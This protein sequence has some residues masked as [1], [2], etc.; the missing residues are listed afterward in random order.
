MAFG[1]AST[2]ARRGGQSDEHVRLMA[3]VA[4]MYHEKGLRQADIAAELHI[5]QP[6]VSR[7]LKQAVESG[8]VRTTVS[9]PA[10]VHTDLED[11]LEAAYG[12][13]EAVVVEAGGSESDVLRAL[14][15]AAAVYLETTFIGGDEVGISSWSAS[16]L[17][18]V[19]AMRP[20]STP[21]VS[22]VVQLVGGVG[23]PR[24]Q[25]DATR[26][27]TRL[28]SV[29]GAAPIFLPSP[30]LLGS[31]EARRSLMADPAVEQVTSLWPA[32]TTALVGIGALEPSPLLQQSGNSISAVD[33]A[34]LRAAGA[35]G[36][37]CLRYFDAAGEPVTTEFDERVIGITPEALRLIPR[38]I[39]VA[40]GSRKLAAV[41][42]ALRGR[43]VT[44]LITDVDSARALVESA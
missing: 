6:R 4:R 18:A 17:A 29:T 19:E 12:L 7:L 26:L 10:G 37:V 32:L 38:R 9:L 23:E 1:G 41:R 20:S 22:D 40:G 36:D 27:L 34:A 33:Q 13:A 43:W 2:A 24:V 31:A 42:G 15:S 30:G 14:G 5:S 8:V 35:V 21:V 3:K 39:A 28:A 11:R 25:V 44:V 16:L